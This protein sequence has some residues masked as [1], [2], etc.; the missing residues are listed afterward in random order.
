MQD[1][2]ENKAVGTGQNKA[3]KTVKVQ[4]KPKRAIAGLGKAGDVVEMAESVAK[5]YEREGYV[6]ILK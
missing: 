5:R 2:I 1:P 4:I 3:E 6:T